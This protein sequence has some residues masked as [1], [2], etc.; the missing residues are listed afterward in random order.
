MTWL[1]WTKTHPNKVFIQVWPERN[2]Y[3]YAYT[4]QSIRWQYVECHTSYRNIL[5]IL[6]KKF[7]NIKKEVSLEDFDNESPFFSADFRT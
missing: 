7:Q 4:Y 2:Q 6:H 1:Q 3:T 5:R